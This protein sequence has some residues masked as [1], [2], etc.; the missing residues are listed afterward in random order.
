MIVSNST[1]LIYLS[2]IGKLD[3][4]KNLFQDVLIPAEV[5]NEVV[6]N[7]KERNYPDAFVVEKAVTDGWIKVKKIQ[8]I[9]GLEEFGIDPGEAQ[10]I[11]LAKTLGIP[12]LIDQT[13]ARTAAK[14]IGLKP[15]GTIFVLF[16]A[17]RKKLMT[18]EEYYEL[19]EELVKAGFRMSDDVYLAALR[20]GRRINNKNR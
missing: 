20:M 9:D 17:L 10:S 3:L 7:G 11:S 5:F 16:A 6:I 12:V 13:H 4:L 2:K 8:V 15:N 1:V 18:H 19:L 14:A